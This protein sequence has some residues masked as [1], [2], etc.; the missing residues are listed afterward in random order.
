MLNKPLVVN[1]ILLAL[2]KPLQILLIAHKM[3]HK[4]THAVQS[5]FDDQSFSCLRLDLV[6]Q[7]SG[8]EGE[9][10]FALCFTDDVSIIML[11]INFMSC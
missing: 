9:T 1:K 6:N 10:T 3:K 11:H 7:S 5:I 2:R 4:I 8:E